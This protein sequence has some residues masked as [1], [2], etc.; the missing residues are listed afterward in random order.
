MT[1]MF[2]GFG[3]AVGLGYAVGLVGL[4]LSFTHIARGFE[5]DL[6]LDLNAV[7]THFKLSRDQQ[8]ENLAVVGPRGNRRWNVVPAPGSLSTQIFPLCASTTSFTIFV[9]RPVPPFLVLTALAEKRRSRISGGIPRPVSATASAI[10]P[11]L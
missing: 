2:K 5:E 8:L 1:G 9:P 11:E 7:S 10:P 3:K 4:V 6:G